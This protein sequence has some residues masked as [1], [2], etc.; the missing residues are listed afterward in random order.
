MAFPDRI[1]RTMGVAHPPGQ[2][3][4]ARTTAKG[5]GTWFGDEATIDLRPGG[6]AR[7]R[8]SHGYTIEMRVERAEEPAVF[9]FTWPIYGLPEDAHGKAY[10]GNADGVGAGAGRG[11]RL[12]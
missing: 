5:L 7:T 10:D 2:V 6:L 1:G 9:D 8:W 3:W 11:G 4:A 12:P